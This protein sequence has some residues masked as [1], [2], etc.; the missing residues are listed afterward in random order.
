MK[1]NFDIIRNFAQTIGKNARDLSD[2]DRKM[3]IELTVAG[4]NILEQVVVDIHRIA[5]ALDHLCTVADGAT[6]TDT[7]RHVRMRSI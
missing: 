6:N 5:D 1:D 2:A 7:G 4:I 3:L